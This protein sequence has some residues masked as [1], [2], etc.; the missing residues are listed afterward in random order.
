MKQLWIAVGMFFSFGAHGYVPPADFIIEQMHQNRSELKNLDMT[1]RV[2]DLVNQVEFKETVYLQFSTGRGFVQTFTPRDERLSAS[3][4]ELSTLHGVGAF[5]L[6]LS[7]DTSWPRV[8]EVLNTLKIHPSFKTKPELG[9]VDGK[10]VWYW[11]ETNRVDVLKDEF[12][13]IRFEDRENRVTATVKDLIHVGALNFPKNMEITVN[14][15]L[16]YR[17]EL[18]S[19]KVNTS[20]KQTFPPQQEAANDN[21]KRWLTLVH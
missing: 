17:V 2:M 10:A 16:Q 12:V 5:W 19:I 7:M 13:P 1:L 3:P 20:G 18:K 11:S 14:S 21:V 6:V 4:F 8:K 9:R 15:T